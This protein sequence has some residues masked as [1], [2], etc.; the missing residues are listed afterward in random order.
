MLCALF[1]GAWKYSHERLVDIVSTCQPTLYEPSNSYVPGFNTVVNSLNHMSSRLHMF[2][3]EVTVASR[4]L[5][6]LGIISFVAAAL[7]RKSVASNSQAMPA[8]ILIVV[9]GGICGFAGKLAVDSLGGSGYHWLLMWEAFCLVHT[10]GTCFTST[11]YRILNGTPESVTGKWQ[12]QRQT[13]F[14]KPW[15][16][17]FWFHVTMVLVLPI[18]TGLIPFAHLREVVQLVAFNFWHLAYSPIESYL[19]KNHS[20]LTSVKEI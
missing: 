20:Q 17:R 5:L 19:R 13:Y 6:G 2:V 9:L 16:R 15:L 14:M 18:L 1:F 11:L 8:T 10:L 4:M 3:C 7:L 12:W